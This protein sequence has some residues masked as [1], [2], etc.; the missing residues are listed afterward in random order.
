MNTLAISNREELR[1]EISRLRSIDIEQ[2]EALALRFSSPSAVFASV[3]SLFPG[4]QANK[5]RDPVT[6]IARVLLPLTLN[7]TLFRNSNFLT[8]LIGGFAAQKAAGLVTEERAENAWH[9]AQSL[10]NKLFHKK[11]ADNHE[12]SI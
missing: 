3:R 6:L 8:R 5:W 12:K 9:G 2:G 11:S 4:H 7:K 1:A 10:F